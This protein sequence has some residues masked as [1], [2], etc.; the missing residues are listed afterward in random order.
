MSADSAGDAKTKQSPIHE[1][2]YAT[3][4]IVD[5]VGTIGLTG[6]LESIIASF[7]TELTS[8]QNHSN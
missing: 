2:A 1:T 7:I 8:A 6:L 3:L 4:G 5:F